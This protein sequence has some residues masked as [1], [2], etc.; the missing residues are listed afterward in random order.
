MSGAFFFILMYT[1][2]NILPIA[3][4]LKYAHMKQAFR[5]DEV[6]IDWSI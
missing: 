2:S 5:P 4:F 6:C 1:G 3:D